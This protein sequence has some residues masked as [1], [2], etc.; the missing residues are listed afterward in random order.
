VS[1]DQ[2]LYALCGVTVAG[3]HEE[4]PESGNLPRVKAFIDAADVV[5]DFDDFTLA[6]ILSLR[7]VGP[8]VDEAQGIGQGLR[9]ADLKTGIV[10]FAVVE[11]YDLR[12][13]AVM[14]A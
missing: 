7:S 13:A 6:G 4:T 2:L 12:I 9:G 1:E 5:D 8:A 11:F 10:V 14:V 3:A